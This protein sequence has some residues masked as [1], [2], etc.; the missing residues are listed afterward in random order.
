MIFGEWSQGLGHYIWLEMTE[1]NT[2]LSDQI[3]LDW[4]RKMA[5]YTKHQSHSR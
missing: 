5:T 4:I 2:R 3:P 1:N